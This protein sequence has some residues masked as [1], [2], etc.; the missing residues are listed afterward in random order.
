MCV[1]AVKMC[2]SRTEVDKLCGFLQML[3]K[4]H[5]MHISAPSLSWRTDIMVWFYFTVWPTW[6]LPT[7]SDNRSSSSQC[8]WRLVRMASRWLSAG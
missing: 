6:N 4:N 1:R 3:G 5:A 8:V 2:G 7:R